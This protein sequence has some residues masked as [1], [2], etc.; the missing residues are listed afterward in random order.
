[1]KTIFAIFVLLAIAGSSARANE[2]CGLDDVPV[3]SW[4]YNALEALVHTSQFSESDV[5]WIEHHHPMTRYGFAV[6][7]SRW[8]DKHSRDGQANS[9]ASLKA[10]DIA[11]ALGYEFVGEIAWLNTEDPMHIAE[12]KLWLQRK[13]DEL[14]PDQ[15]FACWKGQANGTIK[16]PPPLVY[17]LEN[18]VPPPPKMSIGQKL[19]EVK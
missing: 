7:L 8:M 6:W 18:R 2:N 5:E 1:M 15:C 11:T 4:T 9:E 17:Q 14:P 12:P 3:T 19:S 16:V 10:Q 13:R